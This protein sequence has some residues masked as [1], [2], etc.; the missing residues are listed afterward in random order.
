M[1]NGR[2]K[3][4][5]NRNRQE[6]EHNLPGPIYNAHSH[7][8]LCNTRG[9]HLN[10]SCTSICDGDQ[11][12]IKGSSTQMSCSQGIKMATNTLKIIMKSEILY[13]V[14]DCKLSSYGSSFCPLACLD[15]GSGYGLTGDMDRFTFA[16]VHTYVCGDT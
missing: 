5:E 14:I 10:V 8:V 9:S 6:F 16:H 11:S 2:I 13:T 12:G 4:K 3:E 15:H 7:A 1:E